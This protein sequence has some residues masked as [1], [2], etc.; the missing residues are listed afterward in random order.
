LV[1][2]KIKLGFVSVFYNAAETKKQSAHGWQ[3]I[4]CKDIIQR[5]N[6]IHNNTRHNTKT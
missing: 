1:I 2:L 6:T 5:H 4:I 3:G